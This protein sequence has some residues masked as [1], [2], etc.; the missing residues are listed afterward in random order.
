MSLGLWAV[1]W[2]VGP[3]PPDEPPPVEVVEVAPAPRV[4]RPAV[5]VTPV[6]GGYTVAL[7]RPATDRLA[8]LLARTDEAAVAALRGAAKEKRA[9][10]PEDTTAATLELL[11]F[12]AS[13]QL[14][15]FREAL[16]EKTGPAGVVVTVTG[17]QA[18]EVKFKRPRLA[19]AAGL[20]R[21]AMPLLPADARA[22]V[23]GLRAVGRTTPLAW[24][25]EP[26]P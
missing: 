9:A 13:S 21:Q 1:C 11:A 2:A 6:P 25:V 19:K 10:D 5:A 3:V 16:A 22:A 26:Q 12:V 14:P 18:P 23:D 8:A 15:G 20:L 7:S 17:L 24:K 4:A